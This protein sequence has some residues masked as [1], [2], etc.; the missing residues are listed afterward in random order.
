MH[1]RIRQT[2]ASRLTVF[3]VSESIKLKFVHF[4]RPVFCFCPTP[5]Y[6]AHKIHVLCERPL[7]HTHAHIPFNFI[8][9]IMRPTNIISLVHSP[10][11]RSAFYLLSLD[12]LHNLMSSTHITQLFS[13]WSAC[14]FCRCLL[15]SKSTNCS[16]WPCLETPKLY[17][18][19]I[20]YQPKASKYWTLSLGILR[21]SVREG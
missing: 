2:A 20:F 16:D 15:G 12:K 11:L 5:S 6:S 9:F 10:R 21:L 19:L 14:W 18:H 8:A 4:L 17:E 1:I 3:S 7:C 13:Q